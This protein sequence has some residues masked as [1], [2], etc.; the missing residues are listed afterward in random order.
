M[1][2]ATVT[3]VLLLIPTAVFLLVLIPRAMSQEKAFV[4]VHPESRI[5]GEFI[6][7]G[8]IAR[9][10]GGDPVLVRRLS[11]IVIGRA[12]L[13]GQVRLIGM[14][15][16]RLRLKQSGIP[17]DDTAFQSPHRVKV[18]RDYVEISSETVRR[19]VREFILREMP[20]DREQVSIGGMDYNGTIILPRGKI[21][22][23]VLPQANEDYLGSTPISVLFK[24]DGSP[25]KRVWLSPD[26]KVYASVVVSSR[27]MPRYHVVN[28]ADLRVERRNLAQL[29]SNVLTAPSEAM[30]KRIKTALAA[31]TAFRADMLELPPLVKKGDIVRVI[32]ESES[33]K[34]TTLGMV[35]EKGR[36]GDTVRVM[37]ITSQKEIYGK[38]VDAKTVR[39]SFWVSN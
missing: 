39:V 29:P 22:Y 31:N 24:V 13:P 37:N 32:A 20:W 26:V 33:M 2:K 21:T 3:T 12:P 35:K 16:I 28:K 23:E 1:R 38:V 10:E 14:E 6:L 30:G 34:V 17:L 15:H 4:S 25:Q 11:S 7:L 27:P 36:R 19:I 5:S 9:I 8:D 18:L